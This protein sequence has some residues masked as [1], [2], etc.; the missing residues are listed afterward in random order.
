[1]AIR[2]RSRTLALAACVRSG[3]S[4]T[5]GR[6][7][8]ISSSRSAGK[9]AFVRSSRSPS[10]AAG[11][12]AGPAAATVSGDRLLGV[13]VSSAPRSPLPTAASRPTLSQNRQQERFLTAATLFFRRRMKRSGICTLPRESSAVG[14]DRQRKTGSEE[15]PVK[16]APRP[17]S[18]RTSCHESR[19]PHP[20]SRTSQHD[21][22]G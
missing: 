5:S 15:C 1:M 6:A 22:R 8:K 7:A 14:F 10:A 12:R 18:G 9:Y 13:A 20:P 2:R 11:G 3:S 21:H 19:E 4:Q 16:V 17:C